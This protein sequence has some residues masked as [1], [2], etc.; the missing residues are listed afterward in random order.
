M[1]GA[2]ERKDLRKHPNLEELVSEK[3]RKPGKP[4]KSSL[5]VFSEAAEAAAPYAFLYGPE[6]ADAFRSQALGGGAPR[7]RASGERGGAGAGR[8]GRPGLD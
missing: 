5:R 1:L 8:G 4:A 6:T 7:G 3:L 2:E